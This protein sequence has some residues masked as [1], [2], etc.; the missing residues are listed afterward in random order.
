MQN[1]NGIGSRVQKD[2]QLL[3]LHAVKAIEYEQSDQCH[4]L[5]KLLEVG[6]QQGRPWETSAALT[7][8]LR[9]YHRFLRVTTKPHFFP[10][11]SQDPSEKDKSYSA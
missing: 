5:A 10:P 11:A 9:I 4:Q 8:V 2:L 1:R 3:R 7:K 6:T